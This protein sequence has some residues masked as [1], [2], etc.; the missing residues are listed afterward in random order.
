VLRDI[1]EH[2]P[3]EHEIIVVDDGSSDGTAAIAREQDVLVFGHAHNRGYGSALKT[4][5]RH[6]RHGLVLIIDADGTY[7]SEIIPLL[8]SR[9]TADHLDMVVGARTGRKVSIPL[10]RRPA[11]WMIARLAQY[12][13]GE[14]I[15]DVNSGLRVIRRRVAL[16]FL[17]LLPNGFSFTTTITLG[18]LVNHYAVGY[19]PIDYHARVGR[20]KIR[21]VRDTLNFIRLILRI[22]L[23]FAPLK[24]F[25]PMSGFLFLLAV[26]WAL[27]TWLVLGKL[28]DV[29]TMVIVMAAFQIM[30][31]GLLAELINKRIPSQHRRDDP[32]D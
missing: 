15:P 10:A 25:L 28:A 19:L 1:R 3:F 23:Y 18:M 2:C 7:P 20:S 22:A 5:I 26:A 11:K 21:P 27:F 17:D 29:S 16:R 8:V 31:M 9:L 12:V 13:V 4:G 30:A 32:E 14:N 6:A 24:F